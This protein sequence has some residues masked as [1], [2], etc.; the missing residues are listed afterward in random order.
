MVFGIQKE[1][2]YPVLTRISELFM[3]YFSISQGERRSA[4]AT[5]SAT[6]RSAA[7]KAAGR[8]SATRRPTAAKAAKPARSM[9]RSR[10]WR[11]AESGPAEPA[12]RRRRRRRPVRKSDR[13]TISAAIPTPWTEKQPQNDQNQQDDQHGPPNTLPQK[14]PHTLDEGRPVFLRRSHRRILI[15]GNNRRR[16]LG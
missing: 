11:A 7:T 3:R 5:S 10:W 14:T 15:S 16:R 13:A 9:R 12:H 4:G 6:G 1:L 2:R 8:T